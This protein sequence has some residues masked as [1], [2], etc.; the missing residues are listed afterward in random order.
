M[1]AVSI[2]FPSFTQAVTTNFTSTSGIKDALIGSS[3]YL[4]L[5]LLSNL[6]L[7]YTELGNWSI[8]QYPLSGPNAQMV[9]NTENLGFFVY[10]Y[11]TP[12]AS[13]PT[14]GSATYSGTGNVSGFVAIQGA[15]TPAGLS[16]ISGDG[17]L[18]A[19]FATGAITGSLTNMTATPVNGGAT[20]PWNSVSLSGSI[21]TAVFNG[22]VYTNNVFSG[23]T[24]VASAPGNAA[25]LPASATGVFGGGFYGPT[26]NEVGVSWTLR[27][28][29]GSFAT[30]VFGAPRVAPSDARLKTDIVSVGR[31]AEGVTLYD[32]AYLGDSRRFVGVMAQDLA[33]DP[34][35]A[36]AV[37]VADDGLMRVDYAR[38]GFIPPDFAAMAEAGERAMA[39]YRAAI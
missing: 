14:T 17:S 35:F 3:S 19:N 37:R 34:R 7:N 30:G 28:G 11:Q 26:A 13:V 18:T 32:Y 36:D 25:S 2:E 15:A 23:T 38:L 21:S 16:D 22:A 29:T 39:I 9:A 24:A 33:S 12:P 10:G 20:I 8:S 31:L 6:G 5:N 4:N 27:D 1:S